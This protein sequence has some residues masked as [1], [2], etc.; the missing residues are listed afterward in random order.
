MEYGSN[1]LKIESAYYKLKN[2]SISG[3]ILTVRPGGSAKCTINSDYIVRATEY[4]RVNLI[5]E[6]HTDNYGPKTRV[7]IHFVSNEDE[8]VYNYTIYPTESSAGVFSQE[9]QVQ[10]GEY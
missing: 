5:T 8:N 7:D 2:A 3:G 6:G 1:I 10:A 9:I 4:F